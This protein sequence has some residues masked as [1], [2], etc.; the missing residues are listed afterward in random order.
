MC[1]ILALAFVALGAKSSYSAERATATY[2]F[3]CPSDEIAFIG[4]LM[5]PIRYIMENDKVKAELEL[6]SIQLEKFREMDKELV[7]GVR[8]VLSAN[9]NK[10]R[11]L[12]NVKI[13]DHVIAIG[14][15][16]E[17]ARKRTNEILKPHQVTRMK[18]LMLQLKGVLFIP[19]K[20]LRQI[21]KLDKKQERAIDEIRSGIFKKI[22][23]TLVPE[24]VIASANSCKF[25][26]S[27][28]RDVAALL[29]ESEKSIYRLLSPE[30]KKSV[31]QLMG[32][33]F[34]FQ[35]EFNK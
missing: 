22:D 26:A 9:G 1:I 14:K 10:D 3:Y 24:E 6:S 30:Q 35:N 23:E 28:N 13:E 25:V 21:L 29:G 4:E 17:D 34:I 8:D 12:S 19:K 32:K 33:P 31:E 16:S 18:E 11:G 7:V 27:T 5:P 2:S 15:I 20:D